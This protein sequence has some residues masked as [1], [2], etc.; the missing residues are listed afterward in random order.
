MSRVCAS[1]DE[2]VERRADALIRWLPLPVLK[3]DATYM[4]CRDGA[5][6]APRRGSRQ[7]AVLTMG[8]ASSLSSSLLEYGV[9]IYSNH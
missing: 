2:V 3:A 6:S 1:L 9:S 5:M 8:T 7:S 4:K